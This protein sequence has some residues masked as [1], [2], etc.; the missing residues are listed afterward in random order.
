MVYATMRTYITYI[1]H[2][3]ILQI[4]VPAFMHAHM[5]IHISTCCT[6]PHMYIYVQEH[7][8]A[9]GSMIA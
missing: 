3:C 8:S 1:Q 2:T 9:Q 6:Y 5:H 7:V 4:C